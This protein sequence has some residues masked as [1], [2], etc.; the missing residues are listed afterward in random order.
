[1]GKG[2]WWARAWL[3]GSADRCKGDAWLNAVLCTGKRRGY[4]AGWVVESQ[5]SSVE[6]AAGERGGGG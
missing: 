1:M 2:S 6:V 4:V 5:Y 3:A